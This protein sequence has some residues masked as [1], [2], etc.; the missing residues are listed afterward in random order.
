MIK[1]DVANPKDKQIADL[2]Q[3]HTAYGDAHYPSESNT[4]VYLDEYEKSGVLLFGAWKEDECVGIAGLKP[5]TDEH[6]EL[7]SMHVLEQARGHGVGFSLIKTVVKEARGR[8]LHRLSLETGSRDAS[9]NARRLYENSGFEYCEPF[10]DYKEDP[11]CLFMTMCL[12]QKA[13]FAGLD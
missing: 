3:I 7:K 2:I 11:E 10:G 12:N 4:H 8:G 1:I 5:L 9:S 13:D 6:G